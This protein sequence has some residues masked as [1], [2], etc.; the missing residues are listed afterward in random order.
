MG[1]RSIYF[2][3][4]EFNKMLYGTHAANTLHVNDIFVL[5]TDQFGTVAIIQNYTFLQ[6]S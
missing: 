4:L 6:F 2:I 1:F 3:H 5:N